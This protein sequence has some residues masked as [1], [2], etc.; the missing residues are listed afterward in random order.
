MVQIVMKAL[1]MTDYAFFWKSSLLFFMIFRIIFIM[2]L[3]IFLPSV[4]LRQLA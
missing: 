4:G 3:I 2:L 1:Q